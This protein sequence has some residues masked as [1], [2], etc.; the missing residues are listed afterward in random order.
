MLCFLKQ[1]ADECGCVFIPIL[2]LSGSVALCVRGVCDFATKASFAESG[3]ATAVLM[4]NDA[5]GILYHFTH[6]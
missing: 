3:G 1:H 2:Q 4:I 6:Q 5:D